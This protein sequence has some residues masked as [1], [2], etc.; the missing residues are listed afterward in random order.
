MKAMRDLLGDK[1]Q[2]RSGL[3]RGWL[4]CAIMRIFNVG[5]F[6]VSAPWRAPQL[7]SF[8]LREGKHAEELKYTSKHVG[9]VSKHRIIKGVRGECQ[10]VL[11]AIFKKELFSSKSVSRLTVRIISAPQ[12]REAAGRLLMSQQDGES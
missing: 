7:R 11:S 8:Y 5:V 10:Q 12:S 2:T 6:N 9:Y 1:S 4:Q 3:L